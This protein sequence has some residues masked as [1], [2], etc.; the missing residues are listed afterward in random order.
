MKLGWKILMVVLMTLAILVPLTLIRSVIHDRQAYRAQAV[1]RVARGYAGAQGIAG[2]VLV[3]PYVETVEVEEKDAYGNPRKVEREREGRWTFFPESLEVDG[4]IAPA[5][6]RVGLHEVR[7]YELQA[8]LAAG[9]DAAIPEDPDPARRRRIGRP[10]L[11]IGIADVRGIAGAPR[12]RIDGRDARLQQGRGSDEGSGLHARLPAPRAGRPLALQ[13]RLDLALGGTESLALATLAGHNRVALESPWPHPQFN[14]DFSPRTP[15]LDAGGFR[16]EWEISSLAS[17]A[18]AQY[19]AGA[20]LPEAGAA[21]PR[22]LDAVG[23]SLVEP[24]NPYS[25]ADRAS[26]YGL[27]FVLLTFVGFF[28]FELIRQLRI[29]PIQYGLVGLALAIFFLLLVSLSEHVAFGI[30]Y[31]AAAGACIGLLGY[32][33]AHVLHSR[34]RGAGFA[35]ML[36]LLYAALY[37]LLVSEDNALVLGAGLLFAIL[38]AIMVVTRRVDW[39]QVAGAAPRRQ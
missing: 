17:N 11:S 5:T 9:F 12:L 32:Y 24:V 3:V 1:E 2:P 18:R 25:Q 13:V 23:V 19:L 38:A 31:L 20:Q 10:W 4:S 35:A 8:T 27:L 26:K 37:G 14:G 15:K 7:V 34:A 16:A 33:L 22:G 21:G 29:H 36:G 6:R 28:M 30:A 39:Y